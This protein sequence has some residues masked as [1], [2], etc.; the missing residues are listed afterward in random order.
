MNGTHHTRRRI[1]RG[2]AASGAALMLPHMAAAQ[3]TPAAVKI[4]ALSRL[5]KDYD[6]ASFDF[7]GM[8]SLLV[9]LP[10]APDDKKRAL[11]VTVGG[12]AV[13]LAA[14]TR[15]CTHL[16]CQPALPNASQHQMVCPCH[17]STYSADGTV[18]KGPAMRNL[19]SLTLEL[20]GADVYAVALT[21]G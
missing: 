9:R 15:V 21:A 19:A 1:L 4:V 6:T 14:F 3:D 10:A 16:G 12:R 13:Y 18:V 17:G 5:K 7:D 20:R 8:A 2:L 11:A